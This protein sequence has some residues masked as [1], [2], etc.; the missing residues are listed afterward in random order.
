M[1]TD[2]QTMQTSTPARAGRALL[3]GSEPF[4]AWLGD[5]YDRLPTVP[6]GEV[7]RDP[8]RTALISVDMINGFCY[9]GPLS[10]PRV[11]GIVEPIAALMQA[12]H[13][14]GVRR[15][16]L[17]QDTHDPAAPE[18]AQWGPHCVR[19]TS[20]AATV[21][22]FTALP[23]ADEFVVVEKNSISSSHSTGFDA[24]LDDPAQA[25][26]DTF[27]VVGDCTD[28]CTYQL[29]M[30]LK[31]RANAAGREVRVVVPED[32]VQ[33]FDVPVPVAEQLGI[34]PHDGDLHHLFFLYHMA[35]NG[36][37]VVRH[38]AAPTPAG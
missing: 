17:T 36:C 20:E 27:I 22:A 2:V 11:A 37:E 12:V 33:T 25:P 18:F 15:F 35:L 31:I 6:L 30:H 3:A 5:W 23:F 29:A 10:G 38:I 34:L 1:A 14:A 26:V 9:E 16:V 32:C 8:A 4:L 7:V 24:W 13:N 21:S 28:L 19:G